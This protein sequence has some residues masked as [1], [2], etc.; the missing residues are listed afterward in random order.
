MD[1][2]GAIVRPAPLRVGLRPA[3]WPVERRQEAQGEGAA[4]QRRDVSPARN[5]DAAAAA[6]NAAEGREEVD[7][8]SA[9]D[10]RRR[11]DDVPP[12]R[13]VPAPYVD[14]GNW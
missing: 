3:P 13:N 4:R 9:E 2:V 5:A 12:N 6:A 8:V 10:G 1:A 11:V 14:N 7:E